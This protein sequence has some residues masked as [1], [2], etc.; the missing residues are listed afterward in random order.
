MTR[1]RASGGAPEAGPA[2]TRKAARTTTAP[3]T[4]N[5]RFTILESRGRGSAPPPEARLRVGD[6]ALEEFAARRIRGLV[7]PVVVQQPLVARCVLELEVTA[8]VALE[9]RERRGRPEDGRDE[10]GVGRAV[11]RD[12]T[13]AVRVERRTR[14][15]PF[16]RPV[17]GSGHTWTNRRTVVAVG[18]ASTW[19]HATDGHERAL[20]VL[21]ANA[22]CPVAVV[23][24]LEVALERVRR[25]GLAARAVVGRGGVERPEMGLL[26]VA[27]TAD[28]N[29][30]ARGAEQRQKHQSLYVSSPS[31][32]SRSR[33]AP[34]TDRSPSHARPRDFMSFDAYVPAFELGKDR[35]QRSFSTSA[36]GS[37]LV[38]LSQM[39]SGVLVRSVGGRPGSGYRQGEIPL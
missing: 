3:M 39:A 6:V 35:R 11:S 7:L 30:G 32:C 8:G 34:R 22:E 25:P 23:L 14:H 31:C 12:R 13:A 5:V 17:H 16:E 29:E 9:A 36:V 20:L 19:A 27:C 21:D 18:L 15:G 10:P 33:P 37:S 4:E 28:G 1:N 24:D 38:R 26:A 2:I